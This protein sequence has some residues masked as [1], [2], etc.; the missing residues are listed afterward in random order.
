M[1]NQSSNPFRILWIEDQLLE[2]Q[3][4][5]DELRRLLNEKL[6]RLIDI[7]KAEWVEKAEQEIAMLKETPPDLIILDLM[8]PRTEECFKQKPPLVD[9]NAGFIIWHRLR[10]Q[11][12]WGEKMAVVPILAITALSRPLF[13]PMME[14]DK[15]LKWLE[16]PVGPSTTAEEIIKLLATNSA[17]QVS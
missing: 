14:D 3:A 4:G 1:D 6:I 5:V 17:E 10:K 8:L 15:K 11:K 13:R 2:I 16:K 9:L 7:S 12:E